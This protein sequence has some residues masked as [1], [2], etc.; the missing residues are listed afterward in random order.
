MSAPRGFGP[1]FSLSRWSRRKLE[2]AKSTPASVPAAAAPVVAPPA[3]AA[4][5]LPPVESLTLASDFT[6]FLRPEVDDQV[7]RAALKQLFRDPRFNI[8]DGLDTYIDDYTQADPIAPDVLADL[9]QRGFGAL[10]EAGDPAVGG[11]SSAPGAA[12]ASDATPSAPPEANAAALSSARLAPAAPST[13]GGAP[14][15]QDTKAAEVEPNRAKPAE[16]AQ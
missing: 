11:V 7:R 1:R 13:G 5:E 2:A 9:L 3:P 10:P 8:M 16:P 12:S 14:A 4:A 15:A 6:A